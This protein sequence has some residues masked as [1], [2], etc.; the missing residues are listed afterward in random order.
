VL[1]EAGRAIEAEVVFWQDLAKNPGNGFALFGLAQ[2][3]EAQGRSRE[4]TEIR[5]RFEAAWSASDVALK[6]SRF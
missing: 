3:L 5:E 4:A 1:L 6:A 2:S